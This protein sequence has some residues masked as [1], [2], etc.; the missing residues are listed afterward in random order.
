[1]IQGEMLRSVV[2]DIDDVLESEEF[3]AW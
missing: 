2:D 3:T 1:M